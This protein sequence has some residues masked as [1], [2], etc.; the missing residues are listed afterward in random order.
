MN[1]ID[2]L[3]EDARAALMESARTRRF[4]AG[5]LVYG[6]ADDPGGFFLIQHGS[7]RLYLGRSDGRQL[8]LK[9][10][11]AGDLFGQTLS[12]DGDPAPIFVEARTALTTS[13][14]PYQSLQRL[15][16][17]SAEI[18]NGLAMQAA[19]T[20][21]ELM[22]GVEELALLPLP[23]RALSRLRALAAAQSDDQEEWPEVE[24]TQA[25]LASMLGASRQA[26]NLVLQQLE[27]QG[28]IRRRFRH[29]AARRDTGAGMDGRG[30]AY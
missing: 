20:I 16:I 2:R 3:P 25:E 21:R 17:S 29:I 30:I 11:R 27:N 26:L 24:I 13:F 28:H 23:E 6:L 1:W 9:I 8:I 10:C 14:F 22:R 7:V 5:E 19:Q 12:I 4:V 18:A 15:R